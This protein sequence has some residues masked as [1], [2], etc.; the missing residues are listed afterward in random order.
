M[1]DFKQ[2]FINSVEIIKLHNTHV[3]CVDPSV[4]FCLE[5]TNR[6]SNPRNFKKNPYISRKSTKYIEVSI[7]A[8][9][10]FYNF[11]LIVP[12]VIKNIEKSFSPLGENDFSMFLI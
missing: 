5:P 2:N 11:P 12:Q 7:S 6:A 3:D 4:F 9:I 10:S 1:I 8:S